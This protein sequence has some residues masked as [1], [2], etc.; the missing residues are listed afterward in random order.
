MVYTYT[1]EYYST[2]KKWNVDICNDVDGTRRYYA[3]RR[4]EKDDCHMISL[5]VEFSK[6]NH[7]EE[8]KKKT[9][10]NKREKQVIRDSKSQ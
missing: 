4:S 5:I 10:W 9:R 2:I 1:M 6:Q 8:R 7:K 3:K